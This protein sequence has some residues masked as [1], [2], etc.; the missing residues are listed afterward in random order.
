MRISSS[1]LQQFVS[2][3]EPEELAQVFE[4]AGIG[5][6]EHA[7]E[8]FSLEITSNRGDWLSATG[9]AREVAAM[10]DKK[11]R[12][13]SVQLEDAGAPGVTVIEIENPE[14]CR[15][16]VAR[17]IENVQ[18]GPSPAWL[19]ERLEEC[20]VRTINNVV[21]ITNFVM[22]E[23]GQ[24]LHAF[25]AAKLSG[26]KIEVRRARAGETL[27]TLD[28]VERTLSAEVLVIA[29]GEKPIGLA[30]VMG[31]GNSEVSE[32]TTTILLESA[33]FEPSRVRRGAR[34][35][36][37]STDA[38]RRFERW[39][40]PN[41]T[42]R[43]SDRAVQLLVEHAGAKVSTAAVDRYS[44]PVSPTEV[45]LR[46]S[47]CNSVLGLRLT[48]ETIEKCLE[49][50][51]FKVTKEK[52]GESLKASI[53][54]FRRDI[55]REI[56]LIEEVARIHGYQQIPT[57]LPRTINAMAGRSLSQRLEERAKSALLRCGLNE[58]IT[59]SM[60]NEAAVR[61]AGMAIDEAVLLRNPLSD[62]YT[63]LR[64]W[65]LP[66]LLEVLS[67]NAR[68]GARVFEL[69][70]VY[71]PR[72]GQKQPD[73]K[74]RLAFALLDTTTP[75][76][77]WQPRNERI[78][79]FFAKGIVEILLGELG[80]PPPQWNATE[81]MPFHP[82]RCASIS[83][84]G[85]DLGIMG[86]VHPEVAERY[87]LPGRA[88]LAQIDFDSLVRHLDLLKPYK[89]LS[90][91]PSVQRDLAFV[92]PSDVPASVVEN[93][94]RGAGGALLRGV[95]TFDVYSGANIPEGHKSLAIS[96]EFRADDR[97]LTDGEADAALQAARAAVEGKLGAK[98]R[99]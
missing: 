26:N 42:R 89:P 30:G 2:V 19:Q 7:G 63:R 77:H 60:Q 92:L 99:G 96:L 32:S 23:T 55:T 9:L 82:G 6:E 97:T 79:F 35:V 16:Y 94:L 69:G 36:G 24:P 86:E 52:D 85:Q 75:S 70:K 91:F 13:P 88:Y 59:Y 22:L 61:R 84:D 1:W 37:L 29:D 28:E 56:D 15:R 4:M 80:A 98:L 38:S 50:L 53:P 83:V 40:D 39:V 68:R 49:R 54:T 3:P 58:I 33:H 31:G 20:G 21:D 76:P 34:A 41:G 44:L 81:M 8:R 95:N 65:L 87:D 90:R 12:L 47:R 51:D 72:E 27:T 10:T 71:I 18:V 66:S 57:T 78:D 67:K 43:A 17:I 48:L 46:V 5:V 93:V 45:T 25:D 62:D 14:E 11:L 73:E 64:T 74:R